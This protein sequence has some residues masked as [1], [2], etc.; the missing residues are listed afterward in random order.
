MRIELSGVE[1]RGFH[2]VLEGERRGGQ[3]FRFDG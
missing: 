1:L 3:R 2:G